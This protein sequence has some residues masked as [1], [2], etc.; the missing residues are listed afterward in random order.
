M[1]S[2]YNRMAR[3]AHPERAQMANRVGVGLIEVPLR[4]NSATEQW[5][6]WGVARHENVVYR[7]PSSARPYN[8]PGKNTSNKQQL[9]YGNRA[10]VGGVMKKFTNQLGSKRWR[11]NYTKTASYQVASAPRRIA[12][13]V[14]NTY[15]K[16]KNAAAAAAAK[17]K[18]KNNRN[19]SPNR[20]FGN[21][22][23]RIAARH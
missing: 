22:S 8:L 4:Y 19:R 5:V 17:K 12:Q 3:L 11:T 18:N 16:R 21:R 1:G 13:F 6:P 10:L 15:K 7:S 23:F 2:V 20:S 14:K 9:H